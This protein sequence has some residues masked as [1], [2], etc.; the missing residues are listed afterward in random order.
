M[1]KVFGVT[2][3]TSTPMAVTELVSVSDGAEIEICRWSDTGELIMFLPG[4]G[5]TAWNMEQIA[6]HFVHDFSCVG[7]TRRGI[8]RSSQGD[9]E[10]SIE[11]TAQDCLE[12]CDSLGAESAIWVGHSLGCLEIEMMLRIQPDRVRG[13]VML[14]GAYDHS[15]DELLIQ[16]FLPSGPPAPTEAELASIETLAAYMVRVFGV[17]F[18]LSDIRESHVWSEEGRCVSRAANPGAGAAFISG[19]K[20]PDWQPLAERPVLAV[21]ARPESWV[22]SLPGVAGLDRDLQASYAEFFDAMTNQ[23]ESQIHDFAEVVPEAM[24]GRPPH[25]GHHVHLSHEWLIA[26]W[27]QRWLQE[28][29]Q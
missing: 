25:S 26:K 19:I 28:S 20:P 14:D 27:M 23:K 3:I 15:G 21:F 9:I 4:L 7:M 29:F 13:A 22:E 10:Y 2:W 18:P 11:R 24:I 8:G 5:H 17:R 12:I 1:D 6:S 16:K